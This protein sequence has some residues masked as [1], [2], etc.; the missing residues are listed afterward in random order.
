MIFGIDKAIECFQNDWP[1]KFEGSQ[2]QSDNKYFTKDQNDM[3]IKSTYHPSAPF[4]DERCYKIVI[5]KEKYVNQIIESIKDTI[6]K[7]NK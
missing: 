2:L 5:Q 7:R 3:L 6:K 4:L 1:K